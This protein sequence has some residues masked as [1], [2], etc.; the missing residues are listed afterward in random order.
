MT[1][2]AAFSP[3]VQGSDNGELQ[4]ERGMKTSARC[5]LFEFT[6]TDNI[7]IST[8]YVWVRDGCIT[9]M[10]HNLRVKGELE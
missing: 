7:N 4:F 2:K 6:P 3:S 9:P 8:L 1:N 5:E 10:I